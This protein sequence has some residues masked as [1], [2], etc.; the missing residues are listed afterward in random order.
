MTKHATKILNGDIVRKDHRGKTVTADMACHTLID[1][2]TCLDIMQ[3]EVHLLIGDVRKFV[4]ILLQYL[5]S[6][7]KDRSEEICTGLDSAAVDIV[8]LTFLLRHAIKIESQ[9]V[10]V[11]QSGICTEHE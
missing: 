2:K 9:C 1:I 11:A 7:L 3:V 10:A 8:Y 5:H 6:R 4:V